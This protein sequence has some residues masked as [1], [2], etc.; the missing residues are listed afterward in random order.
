[1]RIFL[2]GGTGFLGGAL[3]ARLARQGHQVIALVRSPQKGDPLAKAGARVVQGDI[4]E[5]ESLRAAMEG[6]EV[7]Y[8]LAAWYQLGVRDLLGMRR[9]N[10]EGTRNVLQ[11]A[12][13]AGARCIV[14]TSSIAALGPTGGKLGDESQAH[15][16]KFGSVYEQTKHEAHLLARE[17]AARGAPV[18]IVLPGTIFGP[19]DHSPVRAL[20]RAHLGGY[21]WTRVFPELAMSL[22][23]VE[24]CAAGVE[25]AAE[26][27]RDGGEYILASEVL[28]LGEWTEQ[29]AEITGIGA[30]RW[31]LPRFL[32]R[33]ASKLSPLMRDG[34][35]MADGKSWSFSAAR[36][37]RELHWQPRELCSALA[38]TLVAM[39]KR[40]GRRFRPNSER[41]RAALAAI[42]AE[43]EAGA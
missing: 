41:A 38:R 4:T 37:R 8:H 11:A 18:R 34:L 3:A 42:L 30:P 24:D 7:V 35:A 31:E 26:H 9:V 15:P 12:V 32:L 10:V 28:S 14:H 13:E 27:G 25:A 20:F 23:Y 6:V 21:L 22:V 2:T 39:D 36:A 17:L 1:M 40:R 33:A 43:P 29:L 16:G 19:Q 5:P